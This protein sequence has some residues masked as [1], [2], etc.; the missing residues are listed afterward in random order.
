MPAVTCIHFSEEWM[1]SSHMLGTCAY[2]FWVSL[3][4]KWIFAQENYCHYIPWVDWH[5]KRTWLADNPLRVTL[6]IT[7]LI[8][9]VCPRNMGQRT[10]HACHQ[11]L[12]HYVHSHHLWTK[13]PRD[14]LHWMWA[15]RKL[16]SWADFLYGSTYN[17]VSWPLPWALWN[18]TV[19][20][21]ITLFCLTCRRARLHMQHTVEC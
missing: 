8:A 15:I 2:C 9:H 12:V 21:A 4:G 18:D 19:Q 13:S 17:G 10:Y 11:V 20:H 6:H 14:D 1:P 3:A 16:S 7:L 5:G